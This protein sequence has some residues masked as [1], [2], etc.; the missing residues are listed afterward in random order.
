[1]FLVCLFLSPQS[2]NSVCKGQ[3]ISLSVPTLVIQSRPQHRPHK[4]NRSRMVGKICFAQSNRSEELLERHSPEDM[5]HCTHGPVTKLTPWEHRPTHPCMLLQAHC[6]HVA[7]PSRH[8]GA[9]ELTA[10]QQPLKHDGAPSTTAVAAWPPTLTTWLPVAIQHAPQ[11][12]HTEAHTDMAPHAL[13]KHALPHSPSTTHPVAQALRHDGVRSTTAD[14]ASPP[15]STTLWLTAA[16]DAHS[17]AHPCPLRQDRYMRMHPIMHCCT[18][19]PQRGTR[20]KQHPVGST[21]LSTM[22]TQQ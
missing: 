7:I 8:M 19:R 1:L 22:H 11:D 12:V 4:L 18:H 6:E 14:A 10:A 3:L 15:A 20:R 16:Q 5:Q 9:A 2:N 21:H 17:E 13:A